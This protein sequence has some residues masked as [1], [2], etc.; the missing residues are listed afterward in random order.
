MSESNQIVYRR[1]YPEMGVVLS[2]HHSSGGMTMAGM[3]FV[4]ALLVGGLGVL[5]YGIGN[6]ELLLVVLGTA[7]F[8][9]GLLIILPSKRHHMISVQSYAEAAAV[10]GL[11]DNHS[12]AGS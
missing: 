4:C 8:V 2:D 7:M 5:F 10:A 12:N 11:S 3:L 9:I 1:Q 6:Q